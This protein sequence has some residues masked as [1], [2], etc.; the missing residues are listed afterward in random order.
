[1]GRVASR[2]EFEAPVRGVLTQLGPVLV[3]RVLEALAS[4]LPRSYLAPHMDLAYALHEH[5]RAD[6]GRWLADAMRHDRPGFPSHH[7]TADDKRVFAQK[8]IA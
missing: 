8:L 1:M 7:V 5:V 2:P 3:A 6:F 4:S